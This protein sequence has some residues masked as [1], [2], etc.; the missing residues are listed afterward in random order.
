MSRPAVACI[1]AC[2]APSTILSPLP[3]GLLGT[4]CIGRTAHILLPAHACMHAWYS[5]VVSSWDLSPT[6][7]SGCRCTVASLT[8]VTHLSVLQIAALHPSSMA[9]G[10]ECPCLN[11][12]AVTLSAFRHPPSAPYFLISLPLS[13]KPL[14]HCTAATLHRTNHKKYVSSPILLGPLHVA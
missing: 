10:P 6:T 12:S 2:M 8:P 7:E 4:A 3:A 9:L 5:E 13:N 14:L 11:P 1:Y